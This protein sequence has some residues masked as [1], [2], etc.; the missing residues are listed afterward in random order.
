MKL[1]NKGYKEAMLEDKALA[2][3]LNV[4][5]GEITYKAVAEAFDMEYTPLKD[6]LERF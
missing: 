1:A 2:K 3:G 6:V 5:Q 4:Y